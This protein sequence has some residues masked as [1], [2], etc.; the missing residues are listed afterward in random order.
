[1]EAEQINE[2][3]KTRPADYIE[4]QTANLNTLMNYF[5]FD[6]DDDDCRMIKSFVVA[7]CEVAYQRGYEEGINE[8]AA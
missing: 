6:N 5:S 2:Q 7:M 1:M 3:I 4:T 8:K